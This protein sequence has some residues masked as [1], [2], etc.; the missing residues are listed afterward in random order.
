MSGLVIFLIRFLFSLVFLLMVC[1]WMCLF[2]CEDR[3]WIRCGKWWN[4]VF[5]GSMCILIMVFCRLWVLCLS[6]FRLVN[7]CLV[8]IGFRVCE[9]CLSMVWVMISLLI[10]LISVL[11]FFMVMWIEV[12]VLCVVVV[13][14]VGV[15]VVVGVVGVLVVRFGGVVGWMFSL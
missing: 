9:I 13:G 10:R 5:I 7:S 4:I 12:F 3:L 15:V 6:R 1:R 8:W 14:V 2:R 11:I